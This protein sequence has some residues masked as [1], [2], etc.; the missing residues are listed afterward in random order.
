MIDRRGLLAASAGLAIAGPTPGR[1][2]TAARAFDP[3]DLSG[4]WTNATFTDLQRPKELSRLVLSAAEAEAYEQPLRALHGMPAAKAGEVGQSESEFTDRGAGLLRVRGEIRSSLITDPADGQIPYLKAIRTKLEVDLKP[5]DRT[6]F[7]DNP[8]ERPAYERCLITPA[9]TAPLVPGPDT[10]VYRFVQTREALAIVAEKF[11]DARI[12][13]LGAPA[14]PHPLYSWLGTSVGRWAGETLV[15]ETTGF[16]PRLVRR[17]LAVSATTRVTET[18][19]RTGRAEIL[20]GFTVEDP[21]LY[22]RPWRGEMLFTPA[23]GP[24]YE[25]ACHEGN[26]GL[27]DILL[28]ARRAEGKLK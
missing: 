17:G 3:R 8:E 5:D 1:S 6:V 11:H 13:R 9:T 4:T 14:E 7:L 12:V 28:G 15:V 27:P 10:N 19:L 16:G 18:F 21:S 24:L 25:Y 20:Y 22:T 26:Y 2:R 23:P